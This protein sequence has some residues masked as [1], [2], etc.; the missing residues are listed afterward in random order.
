MLHTLH[1]IC[2]LKD[3]AKQSEV[4]FII[5]DIPAPLLAKTTQMVAGK[6]SGNTAIA[7]TKELRLRCTS[8]S[9]PGTKIET[10]DMFL[11][12]HRKKVGTVQNKSGTWKVKVTED[13]QGSVLNFI[14]AWCDLIHSNLLG[15]RLPTSLYTTNACIIIG[16]GIK[17]NK[18]K[19]TIWLKGVWPTGY[20]VNTI[21]PTSSNPID[22]DISFNYDY[23]ADN[24]YSLM[25]WIGTRA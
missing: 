5:S 10:I 19:R 12:H 25:S 13:Y 24:S 23:F 2:G 8:F 18:T 4:E 7:T 9:Y 17:G 3:P 21:N 16:E 11:G 6:L 1:E 20:Q 14:Q 22:V 15:T